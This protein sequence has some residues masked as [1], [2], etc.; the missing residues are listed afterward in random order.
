M[1]GTTETPAQILCV[2][3]N[4]ALDR[5]LQVP[6]LR[7]GGTSRAAAA[8]VAAG[9]KGLNVGRSLATL[10]ASPVCM[11]PLGGASGRM[12]ADLAT[13]EGLAG[14]WTWCEIETRTCVILV[15][16]TAGRATVV[17]ESGPRL[18]AADWSRLTRDVL[19]RA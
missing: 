15:E 19:A 14:S 6:D 5:T 8:R 12:L 11:G 13:A 4:P 1:T 16:T 17:N 10:R 9:G 2:T 3:P 18:S 7:I